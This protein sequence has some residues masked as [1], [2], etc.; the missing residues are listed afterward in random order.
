M[1]KLRKIPLSQIPN[2]K[3]RVVLGGQNCTVKLYQRGDHLYMDLAVNANVVMSGAICMANTNIVQYESI[4][5]SGCLFFID[6]TGYDEA[7]NYKEFNTR[8]AL[9]FHP[10]K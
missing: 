10:G 6:K 8:F 2:Q 5:F 1:H 7:P 9:M 3:F 4:H